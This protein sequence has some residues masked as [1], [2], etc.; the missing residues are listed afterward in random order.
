LVPQAQQRLG[1]K[2]SP[3][4]LA[5]QNNP[6]DAQI[7]Q[8]P[9]YPFQNHLTVI[10]GKIDA[11]IEGVMKIDSYSDDLALFGDTRRD[12]IIKAGIAE[13]PRATVKVHID[14]SGRPI[15][16]EKPQADATFAIGN[17]SAENA[18]VVEEPRGK[19][20][21][22]PSYHRVDEFRIPPVIGVV[23]WKYMQ[24][25]VQPSSLGNLSSFK[26]FN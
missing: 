20:E 24:D 23:T 22:Q 7:W 8:V 10:Y 1:S 5:A 9:N 4:R 25:L 21:L 3:R 12:P 19:D 26:T 11:I 16:Q 13:Y 15:G 14:T 18:A 2:V 17:A 6:F